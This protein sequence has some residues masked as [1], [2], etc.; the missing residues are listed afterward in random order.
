MSDIENQ[1]PDFSRTI[2]QKRVISGFAW[3]GSTKI[4]I[5][6]L[7]WF[8][9]IWVARIL[10]PMD[11]GIVAIGSVFF[12]LILAFSELG[13]A[14]GLIQTDQVDSETQDS[15]LTL[16][17]ATAIVAYGLLFSLAPLIAAV[18][19]ISE[20]TNILRLGGLTVFF[21]AT[22]AVPYA[23]AMRSLNYR[24]RS[25][26]EFT[27]QCVQITTLVGCAVSGYGY[28][29]LVWSFMAGQITTSIAYWPLYGRIPRL[30]IRGSNTMPVVKFGAK[31]TANRL[32]YFITENSAATIIGKTLGSTAVG[33]YDMAF[34][35]AIAPLDKVAHVVSQVMFPA[36][37]RAEKNSIDDVR[38]LYLNVHRILLLL[39]QPALV[40]LAI[41]APDL[42]VLLLTE[43]W[44]PISPIVQVFC[45]A[46]IFRLSSVTMPPIISGCGRPGLL[47]K[48]T[49]AGACILPLSLLIGSSYDLWGIVIAWAI[50]QPV[51]FLLAF[52]ALNSIVK[53][54]VTLYLKTIAPACIGSTAMAIA[55]LAGMPYLEERDSLERL[56]VLV[57]SGA[58]VYA[59][60]VFAIYHGQVKSMWKTVAELRQS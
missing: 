24:Y 5:Q 15:V 3:L 49:L 26:V 23:L 53:I 55:L 11:Y 2:I 13:L 33:Y 40:G 9:T 42:I 54:A 41:V 29:S 28:W 37:S 21:A 47:V 16:T 27:A 30:G 20:L 14:G 18:F 10:D 12:S 59:A 19:E 46:N 45:I 8:A 25:L 44:L 48:L 43:K 32:T 31:I 52:M 1:K 17:I 58:I 6:A 56:I 22:K 7:S 38:S 51:L 57:P 35:L 39:A 60:T 36:V 4:V 50:V 34:Q